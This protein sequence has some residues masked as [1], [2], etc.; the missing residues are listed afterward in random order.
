M[1]ETE[2]NACPICSLGLQIKHTDILII[3]QFVRSDG[4][5]LPRRVTALCRKEQRRMSS[6]VAMA[7]KA[8]IYFFFPAIQGVS[9]IDRKWKLM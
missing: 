2:N 1:I 5:M 4:R 3:S 7:H 6:L 9:L 8:G